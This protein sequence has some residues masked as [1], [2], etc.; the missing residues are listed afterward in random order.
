MAVWAVNELVRTQGRAVQALFDAG[1][2][3]VRAQSELVAERGDARVLREVAG[4]ER[5]AVGEL[6]A[7]AQGLLSAKDTR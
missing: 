4:R 7:A 3:L 2:A 1:D 6:A 5:A